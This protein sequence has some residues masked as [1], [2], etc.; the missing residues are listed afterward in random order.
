VL[1]L[2]KATANEI[3]GNESSGSFIF[4]FGQVSAGYLQVK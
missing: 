2:E 4:M 3:F 1:S